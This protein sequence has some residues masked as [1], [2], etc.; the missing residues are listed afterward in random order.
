[1]SCLSN[2]CA[3]EYFLFGATIGILVATNF[4]ERKNSK[5][6][7]KQTKF[8]TCP[9]CQSPDTRAELDEQELLHEGKERYYLFC[10]NLTCRSNVIDSS[11]SY[12]YMLDI[13]NNQ[14]KIAQAA[15]QDECKV[16]KRL[17]KELATTKEDLTLM[18]SL[19]KILVEKL[20]K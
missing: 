3:K 6:K 19:V 8:V 12:D 1:L 20:N 14:Y 5:M 17:E 9:I 2:F 15:F 7:P 13:S 11:E 4:F 18:K 16:S 10:T